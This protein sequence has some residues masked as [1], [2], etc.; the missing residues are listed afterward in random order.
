[1]QP[2]RQRASAL[3]W[4][5]LQHLN[6]AIF[7]CL[8]GQPEQQ[9]NKILLST[10]AKQ[11]TCNSFISAWRLSAC[12]ARRHASPGVFQ[13]V[14]LHW[15]VCGRGVEARS[16]LRAASRARFLEDKSPS[17]GS[18][19]TKIMSLS[20]CLFLVDFG[21]ANGRSAPLCSILTFVCNIP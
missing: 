7:L 11:L 1:M 18:S 9:V 12:W 4:V 15:L 8:S 3:T 6:P 20:F 13:F 10:N 2:R 21:F 16:S 19:L 17:T 5:P 14:P